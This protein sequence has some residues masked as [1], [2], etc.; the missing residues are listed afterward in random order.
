[1]VT[2]DADLVEKKRT[3]AGAEERLYRDLEWAG[4]EWDEGWLLCLVI[5]LCTR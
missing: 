4:I 5:I 1:M 3:L 2:H